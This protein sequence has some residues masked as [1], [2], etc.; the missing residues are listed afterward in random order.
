MAP[1]YGPPSGAAIPDGT[2]SEAD[3]DVALQ[4]KVTAGSTAVQPA[5]LGGAAV[6]DVGTTAGTVAA[7]D[8]SRV[9]AGGTAY[10][11]PGTGIPTTDLAQSVKDSVN[12]HPAKVAGWF[13]FTTTEAVTANA[14]HGNEVLKFCPFPVDRS[15][16]L[17][18]FGIEI[19][20]AGA[21]GSV[22][23]LG[24]YADAGGRPGAL[25]SELGTV[26]TASGDRVATL[27]VSEAV[28]AGIVWAAICLQ[29]AA[30]GQPTLYVT[31][32]PA[33]LTPLPGGN[34][35]GVPS[36]GSSP[37]PCLVHLGAISGALP[38]TANATQTSPV[39]P[40]CFYRIA[41]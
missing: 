4:A 26:N 22:V 32:A 11:L 1:T 37:P 21:A 10:Q 8:D 39:V 23:R 12:S 5:D 29:G 27:A 13:Y 18:R 3:L 31:S 38:A 20:T 19:G 14:A 7:G 15:C 17:D 35:A 24:L 25:I 2:V 9:V 28:T 6:L 33:P 36:I 40:R 34:V 16:T 41:A 30:A